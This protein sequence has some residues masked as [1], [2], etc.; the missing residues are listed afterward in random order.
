MS[1]RFAARRVLLAEDNPLNQKVAVGILREADYE[2]SV[3]N[4]G[5][6]AVAALAQASF[7]IVLM[8]VQMPEMDGFAATQLIR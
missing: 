2:I 6:Q 5:R 4:D 7:Y 8:D 3:V 1:D